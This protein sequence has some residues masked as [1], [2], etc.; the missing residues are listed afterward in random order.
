MMEDN[1]D[2]K[3]TC[4]QY[5]PIFKGVYFYH[6]GHFCD[7]LP[8]RKALVLGFTHLTDASLAIEHKE[9]CH[10]YSLWIEHN[11]YAALSTRNASG[12]VGIHITLL[13]YVMSHGCCM[14]FLGVI[15]AMDV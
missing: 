5:I 6:L 4:S 2:A 7:P 8:N 14:N 9:K 3:A 12:I 15:L 13:M 11:A 10:S 1:C